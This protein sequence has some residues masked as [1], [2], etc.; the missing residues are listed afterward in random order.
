MIFSYGVI[1]WLQGTLKRKKIFDFSIYKYSRH[2][3][4]LGYLIWS[5]GIYL[6]TLRPLGGLVHGARIFEYTFIWFLSALIIIGVALYEE[7]LMNNKHQE[8]YTEYQKKVSF[9][10]PLPKKVRSAFT[11]PMR[12][13]FKKDL[14]Q[15]LL[16]ILFLLCSYG[17]LIILISY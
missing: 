9:L 7:V 6:L 10:I 14:P 15:N 3:Q 16:E 13:V 17:T 8:F 4:Y 12:I 1:A 2:P 5:Y 11:F